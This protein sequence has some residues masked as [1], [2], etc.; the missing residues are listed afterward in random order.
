MQNPSDTI[1]TSRLEILDS[2]G[3]PRIVLSIV[4]KTSKQGREAPSIQ[5]LDSHGKPRL[6]AWLCDVDGEQQFPTIDLCGSDGY[7]GLSLSMEDDRPVLSVDGCEKID[8][9]RLQLEQAGIDPL[10]KIHRLRADLRDNDLRHWQLLEELRSPKPPR[11]SPQTT[12]EARQTLA[13]NQDWRTSDE[14]NG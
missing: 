12:K 13:T 6:T 2:H 5:L 7:E 4:P 3:K 10:E 8:L 9:V 11:H 1:R 14:T